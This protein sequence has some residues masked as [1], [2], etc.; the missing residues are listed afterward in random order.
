MMVILVQTLMMVILVQT[1]MMGILV[2]TLMMGI[3]VQ[4]LMMGILVQTLMMGI[5]LTKGK[6][7]DDIHLLELPRVDRGLTGKVG[8]DRE[9]CWGR[10]D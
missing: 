9:E 10:V 7:L 4:T 2:Q 5:L 6:K 8:R 3:L 1:L